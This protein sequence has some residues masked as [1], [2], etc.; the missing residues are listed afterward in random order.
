MQGIY[1]P[2]S[3]RQARRPTPIG[4]VQHV[5]SFQP[6]SQ[7]P[8]PRTW[9]LGRGMPLPTHPSGIRALVAEPSRNLTRWS[10]Q[11][12]L[13][14][15]EG[16]LLIS[17]APKELGTA[18][19]SEAKLHTTNGVRRHCH[20]GL[21]LLWVIVSTRANEPITASLLI[22]PSIGGFRT[23]DEGIAT[24]PPLLR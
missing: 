6:R 18:M 15:M 4:L 22:S 13:A 2:R 23:V 9:A 8:S 7:E 12:C 21:L 10:C 3:H 19:S 5:A 11:T 1:Y 16:A 24:L 17:F 14:N 20:T